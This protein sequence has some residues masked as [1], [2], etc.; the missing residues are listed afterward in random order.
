MNR[1]QLPVLIILVLV[2]LVVALV[3][4]ACGGDGND[5]APTRTPEN[6]SPQIP[7]TSETITPPATGLTEYNPRFALLVEGR[8]KLRACVE[9]VGE[10]VDVTGA[11]AAIE[12]ALL[13]AS[14]DARWPPAWGTPEVDSG[15][16][17]PPVALDTTRGS[18][19]ERT[20]CLPE[21]SQYLV[22]VFIAERSL[23][24]ERFEEQTTRDGGG[25]RKA[26]QENLL[27]ELGC[28]GSVSEAWYL[29]PTE[30]EDS[31][32]LQRFI[33]GELGIFPVVRFR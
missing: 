2:A 29:T 31:A 32:L 28:E 8:D 22:F 11:V 6:L 26:G 21:V 10:D 13:I 33:Y 17:L 27:G 7:T 14:D 20:P 5:A 18:L 23:L 9:A 25:V 16:P 24:A 1:R 4:A 15:C 3:A 30:L 12:E 19:R